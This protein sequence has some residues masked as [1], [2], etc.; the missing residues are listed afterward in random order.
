[1]LPSR[2]KVLHKAEGTTEIRALE[3]NYFKDSNKCYAKKTKFP[4]NAER[5]VL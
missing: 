4:Q 3:S 2:I 1:M 5:Y